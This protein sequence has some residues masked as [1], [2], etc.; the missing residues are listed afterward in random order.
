MCCD[1]GGI[2]DPFGFAKGDKKVRIPPSM[3]AFPGISSS[4]CTIRELI[5]FISFL[6]YS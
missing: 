5:L 1:V 6:M 3:I 2:F 4:N